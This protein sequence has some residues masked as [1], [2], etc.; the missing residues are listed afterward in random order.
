MSGWSLKGFNNLLSDFPSKANSL[1]DKSWP[2]LLSNVLD[3]TQL[4]VPPP[5][6][7]SVPAV[8]SLF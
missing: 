2:Y 4:F 6:S 5:C 1:C 3:S 8:V 7:L